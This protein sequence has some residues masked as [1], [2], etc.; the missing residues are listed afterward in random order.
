MLKVKDLSPTQD[1]YGTVLN[2]LETYQF[3]SWNLIQFGCLFIA[4]TD[5]QGTQLDIL[6]TKLR[7]PLAKVGPTQGGVRWNDLYVSIMRMG[8]FGFEIKQDADTSSDYYEEK[9]AGGHNLG[10]TADKLAELING[11]RS[12]LVKEERKE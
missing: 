3:I 4:W 1:E 11:V 12:E 9:L 2:S 5:E 6:F 7:H 10:S 8:A